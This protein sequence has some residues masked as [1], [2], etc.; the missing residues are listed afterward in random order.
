DYVK[1]TV[2]KGKPYRSE[3][4]NQVSL[5]LRKFIASSSDQ[6]RAELEAQRATLKTELARQ[7]LQAVNEKKLREAAQHQQLRTQAQLGEAQEQLDSLSGELRELRSQVETQQAIV[8]TVPQLRASLES[9]EME[10]RFYGMMA[11]FV[12]GLM[13]WVYEPAL[14]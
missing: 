4:I 10:V 7:T 6:K 8:N 1:T 5:G 9:R 2:L 14:Q 12:L 13:Y 3:H 11:G